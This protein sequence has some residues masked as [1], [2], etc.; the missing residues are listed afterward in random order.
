MSP[1]SSQ[2]IEEKYVFLN[3]QK[4][5]IQAWLEHSCSAD[6]AY[7]VGVVSSIYYDTPSLALYEEKRNGDYLKCKVRLRWYGEP[8]QRIEGP[9]MTGY[10]EIKRKTG[11]LSVK[12]R[13]ACSLPLEALTVE[14]LSREE[15]L[16]LP[17][18]VYDLGYLPKGLLIPVLLI[19]YTRHR[20]VDHRSDSRIA[21]DTDICCSHVN[22]A[23][24]PWLAPAHL[25]TGVLEIKGRQRELPRNLDAITTYLSK[26]AFSKYARCIEH[27]M[28]P[29]ERRV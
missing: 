13:K 15:I 23:L 18:E 27:M 29:M 3:Q 7:D 25:D 5:S 9:S 10:L 12:K 16:R 20:F 22:E 14:P 2:H 11:A 1:T 8:G 24:F 26:S 28:Y 4:G 19:R 21:L 6:P 17:A